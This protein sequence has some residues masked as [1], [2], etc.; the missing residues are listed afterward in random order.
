MTSSVDEDDVNPTPY[1]CYFHQ[2]MS[3]DDDD[4]CECHQMM[5]R[6]DATHMDV[7]R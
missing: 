4:P 1:D 2:V 6:D 3:C 5:S 7:I